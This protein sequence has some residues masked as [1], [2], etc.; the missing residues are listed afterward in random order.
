LVFLLSIF[1]P[2]PFAGGAASSGSG[3]FGSGF[4]GSSF[5]VL[6]F[7]LLSS[8]S[9]FSSS[10]CF[11]FSSSFSCFFVFGRS[12]SPMAKYWVLLSFFGFFSSL[13]SSSA[14]LKITSSDAYRYV[15][16]L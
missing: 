7:F 13:F 4:F 1:A 8:L 6:A 3:F 11:L 14:L 10:S 2:C 16:I 15:C 9:A 5:S 12:T